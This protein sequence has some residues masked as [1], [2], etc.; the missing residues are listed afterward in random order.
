LLVLLLVVVVV[1]LLLLLVL[2]HVVADAAGRSVMA[3]PA[4][5]MPWPGSCHG[6]G[7]AM[8]WVMPWLGH[9]MAWVMADPGRAAQ[10]VLWY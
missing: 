8:A 10:P 5:V 3:G 4:W 9:A 1:V 7:H 6:L 2:Q